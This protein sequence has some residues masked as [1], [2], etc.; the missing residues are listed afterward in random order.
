MACRRRAIRNRIGTTATSSGF[1]P[2]P[3]TA[4]PLPAHPRNTALSAG[5]SKELGAFGGDLVAYVLR[6]A[7]AGHM[8]APGSGQLRLTLEQLASTGEAKNYSR[9]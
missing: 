4:R 1:A 8:P 2:L 9:V 7:K 6:R 3:R 5:V